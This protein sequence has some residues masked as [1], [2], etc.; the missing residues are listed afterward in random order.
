MIVQLYNSKPLKETITRGRKLGHLDGS[1]SND[2]NEPEMF[3]EAL[4]ENVPLIA[5]VAVSTVLS[6]Q[7]R[8]KNPFPSKRILP[9]NFVEP[10]ASR[11]NIVEQRKKPIEQIPVI[12]VERNP[13]LNQSGQTKN[14]VNENANVLRIAPASVAARRKCCYSLRHNRV[15]SKRLTENLFFESLEIAA[16]LRSRMKSKKQGSI[17]H[18]HRQPNQSSQSKFKEQSKQNN[19]HITTKA[20][21]QSKPYKEKVRLLCKD[22]TII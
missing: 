7:R 5:P 20:N 21:E 4:H 16:K 18:R 19:H 12:A 15:P 17:R 13:K 9:T 1:N 8:R 10:E 11:K 3:V 14:V 2:V 6:H 22:E